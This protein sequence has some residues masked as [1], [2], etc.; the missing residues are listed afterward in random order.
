MKQKD[1]F[2]LPIITFFFFSVIRS[3]SFDNRTSI[4]KNIVYLNETIYIINKSKNLNVTL[5]MLKGSISLTE[6]LTAVLYY[7]LH[8]SN[9][10]RWIDI[11]YSSYPIG[12]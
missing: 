11:K 4:N 3:M 12:C 1:Q 9:S 2:I 8:P 5:E 7:Q 6:S 10:I